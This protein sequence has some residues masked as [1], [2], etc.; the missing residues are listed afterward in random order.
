MRKSKFILLVAFLLLYHLTTFA[1]TV[2]V[3]SKHFT[4]G[5]IVSEI[6]AQLL[7]QNDIVVERNFNLGG[8]MVCFSALKENE[9]DIYPEY[10]GTI[11]SEILHIRTPLSMEELRAKA[12]DSLQLIVSAPYGF[13]NTYAL[14]VTDELAAKFN[15]STISDLRNHPELTMGL[16]YEFLKRQDGWENLATSYSLPHKKVFGLE[17]GLAYAALQCAEGSRRRS[18]VFSQLRST[19]VVSGR[20]AT[21]SR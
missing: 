6:I 21:A 11:A 7:E 12:F 15:L 13:N 16:S 8:T 1:Q 17:H 14:V 4:E 18:K 10:S 19:C 5:Y 20:T 9:I 2:R 3:G